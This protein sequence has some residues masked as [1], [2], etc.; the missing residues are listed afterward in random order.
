MNWNPAS[1]VF[2]Q[3]GRT[4]GRLALAADGAELPYEDLVRRAAR[5]AAAL[6][7]RG[8][9]RGSRI[10]ILGSRSRIAVEAVLGV[11]WAGAAYVPLGPRWPEERLKAALTL[12]GLDALI[13][14]ARGVEALTGSLLATVKLLVVPDDGAARA[15]P[16]GPAGSGTKVMSL[17]SL[18]DTGAVAEPATMSPDDLAYVIFTSGTTGIPKGVMATAGSLAAYL[19]ALG[20]RKALT[21]EDRAS[22]FF[23]L[24]FDP[25]VGEIFLPWR[26]GASL[27]VAPAVSQAS[28]ARFIRE[29]GLTIW[30]SAPAAIAWMRDTRSLAPGSF[31]R[32]RYTSFGG[33]PLPLASVLAWQ[34]AAPNSVIDNLYGPTEATVDCAGQR[35]EPGATPIVTPG[36]GVLAIGTPHP[37]TEL[38][39]LGPDRR[40]LPEGETGELAIAG[41]QLTLGYLGAPELKAGRF[42]VI[43][44]KRWY[45]TGDIAMQDA[46]GVYHHLGRADNQIKIQGHR[47]ELEDVEAHARA[48]AR[49]DQVAAVAWPMEDGVARAI[50]C[51]VAQSELPASRIREALRSRVPSYMVPAAVHEVAALPLNANGKLDRHALIARLVAGTAGGGEVSAG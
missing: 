21:P 30:G 31:P 12:A 45:L 51:F 11:T 18:P 40:R 36:R 47:V 2:E 37:G 39:V 25:S 17:E 42:P 7:E 9:A 48:V 32:L 19:D 49:T 15:L 8:L 27:H 16:A 33:E 24:T 38:A 4:P 50:V 10:G 3:S 28:P 43:D 29:R 1:P 46:A 13:A 23:E 20:L 41:R 26:T 35:V 34:A 5:L 22:Q 44:G 14:D 6:R